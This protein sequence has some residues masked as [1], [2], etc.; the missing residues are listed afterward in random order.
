MTYTDIL[1]SIPH[2]PV[3]YDGRAGRREALTKSFIWLVVLPGLLLFLLIANVQFMRND[4]A[5]LAILAVT[6]IPLVFIVPVMVRRLRDAGISP[7]YYP[8]MLAFDLGLNVAVDSQTTFFVTHFII[9]ALPTKVGEDR[10]PSNTQESKVR[11]FFF[12]NR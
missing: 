6:W 3:R 7:L 1:A 5:E 4:F 8:L 2:D 10:A 9:S 12:G 11:T